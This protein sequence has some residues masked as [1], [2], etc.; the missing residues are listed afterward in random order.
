MKFYKLPYFIATDSSNDFQGIYT[1]PQNC[2]RYFQDNTPSQKYELQT[3]SSE[4][5]D[6]DEE[7][8]DFTIIC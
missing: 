6:D 2:L 7:R 8:E 5:D 4:F 1:S 3:D